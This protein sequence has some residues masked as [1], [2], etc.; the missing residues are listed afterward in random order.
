M[1]KQLELLEEIIDDVSGIFDDVSMCMDDEDETVLAIKEVEKKLVH[2]KAMLMETKPTRTF[3]KNLFTYQIKSAFGESNL[4]VDDC[5]ENG[6]NMMVRIC[7]HIHF[8]EE[9]EKI[10]EDILYNGRRIKYFGKQP[11]N[12]YEFRDA[13]TGEMAWWGKFPGWPCD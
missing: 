5:G 4:Y 11:H 2:L 9:P 3:G 10:I 8:N 12:V 6:D 7:R 1:S 13:E